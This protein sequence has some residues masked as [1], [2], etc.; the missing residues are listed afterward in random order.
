MSTI[1]KAILALVLTA[2]PAFAQTSPTDDAEA[3]A[4]DTAAETETPAEP[5]SQPASVISA[6]EITDADIFTLDGN[7]DASLWDSGSPFDVV[8]A[9]W[10]DIGEVEDL[11]LDRGGKVVG[12]TADVGGFLGIGKKT[13]L[14]ELADIRLVQTDEDNYVIVTR[15]SADE[16]EEREAYDALD[17]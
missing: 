1:A 16:L 5:E 9:D 11:V 14:L 10:T 3:E 6:D 4:S 2:A 8:S 17:D 15:I 7:Y 12:V 13:V